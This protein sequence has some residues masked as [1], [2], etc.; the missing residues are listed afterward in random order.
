MKT[1]YVIEFA[2]M[3]GVSHCGVSQRNTLLAE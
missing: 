2:E 3:F 1:M